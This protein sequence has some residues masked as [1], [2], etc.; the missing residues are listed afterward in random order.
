MEAVGQ[1][2]MFE[3]P[4]LSLC[5]SSTPVEVGATV[6]VLMAHLGFW[7][8]NACRIVYLIHERGPVDRFGFAY[9][10]LTEHAEVGEERFSV[11]FHA[12]EQA[13]WYNLYAFSRPKGLARF[14]YPVSRA[15]QRRFAT[16]S[17]NAMLKAVEER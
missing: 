3:M 9:G 5:W 14:A 12:S 2:K 17:T 7:S 1:W 11:E 13:V 6:A 10:T 4:Q 15:L 8:L 16:G